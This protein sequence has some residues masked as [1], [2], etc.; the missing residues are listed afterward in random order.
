MEA[1]IEELKKVVRF[2]PT[3]EVGDLVLVVA[4]EPASMA[5]AL[6][7]DFERDDNK[8]DEWWHVGL[9]ILSVPPQKVTWTLRTAQ[10]TG[11][12]IFTMGGEKRFVAAVDFDNETLVP[13]PDKVTKDRKPTL[14]RVK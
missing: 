6:V 7:T 5:Y 8:R 2:K 4:E 12:E 9:Q 10:F 1:I 14:R 13:P 3:T 11:Q